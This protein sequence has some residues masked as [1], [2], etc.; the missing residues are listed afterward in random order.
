MMSKL[1]IVGVAALGAGLALAAS[2]STASADDARGRCDG[3]ISVAATY[4]AGPGDLDNHVFTPGMRDRIEV[5]LNAFGNLRWFC[6]GSTGLTTFRE[7][8]NVGGRDAVVEVRFRNDGGV[9]FACV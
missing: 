3:T 2:A 8:C 4:N 1:S 5:R 6:N 9:R 7:S